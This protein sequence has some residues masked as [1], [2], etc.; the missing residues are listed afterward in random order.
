MGDSFSRILTSRVHHCFCRCPV[1]FSPLNNHS[2]SDTFSSQLFPIHSPLI[3]SIVDFVCSSY[4]A[5]NNYSSFTVWSPRRSELVAKFFLSGRLFFA[6]LWCV[7][8]E[9]ANRVCFCYCQLC[10]FC[11]YSFLLS[12]RVCIVCVPP[13]CFHLFEQQRFVMTAS[14]HLRRQFCNLRRQ[15][16]VFS[17]SIFRCHSCL[18][19]RLL[20]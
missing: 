15:F 4:Q 17:G 10:Q 9:S 13:R 7:L 18:H 8:P 3:S 6:Q 11:Q 20:Q 16:F 5:H 12:A 14:I 2:G 1:E 19:W